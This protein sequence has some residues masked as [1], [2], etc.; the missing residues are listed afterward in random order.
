MCILKKIR[1]RMNSYARILINRYFFYRYIVR[2]NL[3]G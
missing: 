3:I 1:A 2:I